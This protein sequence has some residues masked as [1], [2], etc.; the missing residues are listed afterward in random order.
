[1]KVGKI[2]TF[3]D[4]EFEVIAIE[5]NSCYCKP[6]SKLSF[7]RQREIE[8][9]PDTISLDIEVV[10]KICKLKKSRETSSSRNINNMSM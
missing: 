7:I 5:G 10:S 2:Y 9:Y 1:M 8:R 3:K 4:D 6:D